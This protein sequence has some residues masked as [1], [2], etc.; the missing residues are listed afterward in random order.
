MWLFGTSGDHQCERTMFLKAKLTNDYND[1]EE[2]DVI[3][4][5][6]LVWRKKLG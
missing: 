1:K 6:Q 4:H 3:K 2:I 5:A